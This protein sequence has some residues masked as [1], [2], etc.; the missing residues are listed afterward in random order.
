MECPRPWG[1]IDWDGNLFT[2]SVAPSHW[3]RPRFVIK[4]IFTL[5]GEKA[6]P[7]PPPALHR[8]FRFNPPLC[9]LSTSHGWPRHQQKKRILLVARK[10]FTYIITNRQEAICTV[11]DCR[12]KTHRNQYPPSIVSCGI[13]VSVLCL[14]SDTHTLPSVLSSHI[15]F[16]L[17]I[18]LFFFCPV[19]NSFLLF[20]WFWVCPHS[21]LHSLNAKS[22]TFPQPRIFGW[23]TEG[24]MVR[25]D[26]KKTKTKQNKKKHRA[27]SSFFFFHCVVTAVRD[28]GRAAGV[29]FLQFNNIHWSYFLHC[30]TLR[31]LAFSRALHLLSC[32]GYR[33]VDMDAHWPLRLPP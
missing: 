8:L 6:P 17:Y 4:T 9:L 16:S 27:G 21:V 15:S 19:F 12:W 18:W 22:I 31:L 3:T 33:S 13:K 28:A 11:S 14:A 26:L 30:V 24:N 23:L 29:L 20:I 2:T 1:H 10:S 7:P 5:L 25:Y 32:H